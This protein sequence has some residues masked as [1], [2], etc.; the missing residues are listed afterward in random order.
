MR[1]FLVAAMSK[2]KIIQIALATD[3]ENGLYGEY[4]DDQGRVWYQHSERDDGN[5]WITNWKQL[6]LP[7]EPNEQA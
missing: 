6:E 4:L 2:I 3:S 1:K 7:D 5:E